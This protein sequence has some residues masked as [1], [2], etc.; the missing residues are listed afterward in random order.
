MNNIGK[1]GFLYAK[2]ND[3]TY[4]LNDIYATFYKIRSVYEE[5][6]LKKIDVSS[7]AH[8]ARAIE[9]ILKDE[10]V[11]KDRIKCEEYRLELNNI[12]N[13]MKSSFN[14]KIKETKVSDK[15]KEYLDKKFNENY[16]LNNT[17][18]LLYKIKYMYA[19]ALSNNVDISEYILRARNI[20]FVMNE[21]NN[22]KADYYLE[23]DNIL[24][25]IIQKYKEKTKEKIV[26]FEKNDF[27]ATNQN[28]KVVLDSIYSILY[29]IYALQEKH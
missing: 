10:S 8:R 12:L 27:M 3:N 28:D 25:T 1:S 23:L 13:D 21:E 17:Y 18:V 14:Q 15:Y 29:K 26:D 11:L 6:L 24:N 22:G 2:K 16:V 7:Y 9:S 19:K 20:E 4:L 5:A